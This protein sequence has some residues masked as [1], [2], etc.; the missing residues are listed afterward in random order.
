MFCMLYAS[1]GTGSGQEDHCPP[2]HP[3]RPLFQEQTF[4]CYVMFCMLSLTK[5]C[6]LNKDSFCM[7]CYVL[8]VIFDNML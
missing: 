8:Y 4:V 3:S 2:C 5:C 7:L 1:D 6:K